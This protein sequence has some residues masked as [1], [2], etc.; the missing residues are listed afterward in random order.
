LLALAAG[1]GDDDYN[2]AVYDSFGCL[3]HFCDMQLLQA[4]VF[5]ARG[6]GDLKA[7][8][9]V[10]QNI[11]LNFDNYDNFAGAERDVQLCPALL[12]SRSIECG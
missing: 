1:R 3:C 10:N 12:C 2:G 5:A 9:R 8:K 4:E 6:F 11:F 7:A